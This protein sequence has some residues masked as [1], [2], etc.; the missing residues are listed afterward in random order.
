MAQ[1][2]VK[3]SDNLTIAFDGAV[4]L[5]FNA[6]MARPIR[7]EYAGAVYHIMARGNQGQKI[8]ADDGD[9]RMWSATVSEACRRTGWRIHAWVLM[10]NHYHLLLE[11]PEA[12]LVSGMKWLQG[13][14]THGQTAVTR[15]WIAEH[16][17]MGYESRVS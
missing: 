3:G 9:R 16:L 14:Y 13:T 4:W 15:R 8:Y 12:N 10:G 17:A 5:G 11:T 2:F 1:A 6:V 7:V